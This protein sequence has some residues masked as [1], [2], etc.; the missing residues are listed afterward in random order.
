MAAAPHRIGS[1]YLVFDELGRGGMATVHLGRVLGDGGFSRLVAVKKLRP[2]CSSSYYEKALV[3]EAR[4]G[5]RIRHPNVVQAL[6]VVREGRELVLVMEYVHGASLAQL[7]DRARKRDA[8]G[9]PASIAVS[10]VADTLAGLNAAHDAT[11]ETGRALGIVHRDVSPQNVLVGADGA[12]RLAD[13]GIAKALRAD[14]LT[15]SGA[16]KGKLSYMPPEQLRGF[17]LTR[18]ADVYAAGIMLADC[19]AAGALEDAVGERSA[20]L[21]AALKAANVPSALIE[22]ARTATAPEARARY[23]TAAEMR[24]ALLDAHAR[25]SVDE[26][27]AY[28]QTLAGDDLDLRDELARNVERFDETRAG[29]LQSATTA[30]AAPSAP[31][32][33]TAAPVEVTEIFVA[34]RPAAAAAGSG[35]GAGVGHETMRLPSVAPAAIT[36]L[37]GVAMAASMASPARKRLRVSVVIASVAAAAGAALAMGYSARVDA[38][39]KNDPR[40]L[41]GT[42]R[43]PIVANAVQVD[44]V[45]TV[46]S[47]PI[48]NGAPPDA[49]SAPVPVVAASASAAPRVAIP[50]AHAANPNLAPASTN[51]ASHRPT[52]PVDC[53]PPYFL[54]AQGHKNYRR[55]CLR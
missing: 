14:E 11:D 7:V 19:L 30:D 31:G 22:V 37:A 1:R 28:V 50:P 44:P 15:H 48:N 10:I 45:T 40:A 52:A 39:A 38:H 47:A 24:A 17:P 23:A 49:A 53:D 42:M 13:F 32:A 35:S 29:S 51:A 41:A 16:V 55:E 5:S 34:A 9:L 18:Q 33:A 46:L 21:D 43:P 26:V 54:D 6:D 8:A 4:L 27:A 20:R 3:R 36:P 25:A 2:E 12:A